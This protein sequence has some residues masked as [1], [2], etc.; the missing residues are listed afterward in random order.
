MRHTSVVLSLSRLRML[1][2]ACALSLL[3]PCALPTGYARADELGKPVGRV[4]MEVGQGGFIL[5]ATG[6]KGTLTFKGRT[7]PIKLGGLGVGG[8]GVAK[9]N[10]V[11][12]VYRLAR[13]E[14]F[15]G[16]FFQARAGYAAVTGK[17]VQ[18]LENSNGVILKLRATTKGVALN[19][20]ADGLKI[21]MGPIKNTK[22]KG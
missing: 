12:E 15:P 7:Y 4:T 10:A 16:A 3:L 2:L 9:V 17:G 13:L 11:G 8:L 21:E 6:G 14:D 20:G 1:S 18:W 22:P 5:S 19:L